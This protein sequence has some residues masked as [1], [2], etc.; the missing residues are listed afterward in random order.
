MFLQKHPN[1]IY[2]FRWSYPLIL[3]KILGK[4]ELLKSLRTTSKSRAL[5][6]AGVFYIVVDRLNK[7]KDDYHQGLITYE[8]CNI[9]CYEYTTTMLFNRIIESIDDYMPSDLNQAQ[10][11]KENVCSTL[12][13]FKTSKTNARGEFESGYT[14]RQ[15]TIEVINTNQNLEVFKARADA[16]KPDEAIYSR[17]IDDVGALFHYMLSALDK[18]LDPSLGEPLL[19][20]FMR[21]QPSALIDVAKEIESIS[22]NELFNKYLIYKKTEDKQLKDRSDEAIYYFS[23]LLVLIGNKPINTIKPVDIRVC[24]D[25]Y[26][27]LPRKIKSPYNKMSVEEMVRAV[28]VPEGDRLA[29]KTVK[30]A[31]KLLISIFNYAVNY[32]L[33]SKSPMDA[34]NVKF[35]KTKKNKRGAYSI[36]QVR[37]LL[38]EVAKEKQQ[39]KKWVLRLAAF[40]GARSGEIAQLR[41]QDVKQEVDTGIHYLLITDSVEDDMDD[42]DED[43]YDGKARVLKTENALRMIPIHPKLIEMG[44]LDFVGGC[45]GDLFPELKTSKKVTAW[46]ARF[47]LKAAMPAKDEYNLPLVFHSFRH[48]FV[49]SVRATSVSDTLLQQVVGHMITDAGT[50]SGYTGRYSLTEVFPVIEAIKY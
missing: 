41:K 47:K 24:F 21:K 45:T 13:L 11:E 38:D 30:E 4:R 44:F 5:A 6:K 48:S 49:T 17:F 16:Y 10:I 25:V 43:Y 50:T 27:K 18:K 15:R 31:Y 8:E 1:G 26:K 14:I 32:D 35:N 3:R 2:Y 28:D 22:L 20:S 33:L 42:D 39:W 36:L 40:T 9:Q 19:P 23:V 34:A 37:Q 12:K 7:I 46:F 29:Q